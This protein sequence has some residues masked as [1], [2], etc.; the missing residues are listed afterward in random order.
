MPGPWAHLDDLIRE[1]GEISALPNA[2]AEESLNQATMAVSKATAVLTRV[3]QGRGRRRTDRP[4]REAVR[5]IDDARAAVAL[6]RAALRRREKLARDGDAA[7]ASPEAPREARIAAACH[8]CGEGFVVH[9]ASAVAAPVVAMPMACPFD[10]CD[11]VTEVEFPAGATT[12]VSPASA[13]D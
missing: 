10:G 7:A 11:G 3:T 8:S 5:A 12:R 9:Y 13:A 6:A 4:A 1:L 2:A